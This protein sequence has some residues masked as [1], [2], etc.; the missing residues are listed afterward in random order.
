MTL[1]EL[2]ARI[3]ELDAEIVRLLNER[4]G[5]AQHIG[6]HELG[7]ARVLRLFVGPGLAAGE[8]GQGLSAGIAV[9]FFCPRTDR[10]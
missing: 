1:E 5:C 8:G 10:R 6:E 2:R 7:Q 3:D 9:A 4:A